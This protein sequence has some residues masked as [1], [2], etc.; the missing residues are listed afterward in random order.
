MKMLDRINQLHEKACEEKIDIIFVSP[1]PLMIRELTE[2]AMAQ[3]AVAK[4]GIMLSCFTMTVGRK[5]NS[6]TVV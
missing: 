1:I 6:L 2:M 5:R 3:R 4:E